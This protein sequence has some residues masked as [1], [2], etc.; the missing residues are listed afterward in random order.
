MV[1]DAFWPYRLPEPEKDGYYDRMSDE[2][3][4]KGNAL[5]YALDNLEFDDYTKERFIEDAMDHI[6]ENNEVKEAFLK[7]F[8]KNW[9]RSGDV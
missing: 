2:F 8:Y 6:V 4:P 3:V 1:V 9:E 5:K 7:W